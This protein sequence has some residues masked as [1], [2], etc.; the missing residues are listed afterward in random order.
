MRQRTDLITLGVPDL[1]EA[2]QFYLDGLGWRPVLDIP[3]E[4][5][6][7]QIGHGLL[8]AL[9]PADDLAADAGAGPLAAGPPRMSLAQIVDTEDEVLATLAHAEAAGGTLL[10]PGQ[11]GDFGGFHGYFA[12]PAGFRWEIATNPGWSVA[13]DGTVTLRPI[14]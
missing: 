1:R 2:R 5:I 10:K 14:T 4:I 9:F 3:N 11:R 12:D 6:F 8:L 13:E 7:F